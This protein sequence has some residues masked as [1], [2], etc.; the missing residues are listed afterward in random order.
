MDILKSRACQSMFF[1]ITN[2]Y[3][4]KNRFIGAI[5]FNDELTLRECEK[6]DTKIGK[7]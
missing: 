5:M 1:I 3:L 6:T 4:K 7:L 2:W